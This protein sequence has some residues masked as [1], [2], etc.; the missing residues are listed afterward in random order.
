M[1][2]VPE[3]LCIKMDW[4][5]FVILGPE[6]ETITIMVLSSPLTSSHTPFVF[7]TENTTERRKDHHQDVEDPNTKIVAPR[8]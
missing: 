4:G 8:R 1:R 6:S 3:S 5:S 7:S 2:S